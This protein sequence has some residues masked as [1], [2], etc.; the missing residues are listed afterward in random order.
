MI[1]KVPPIPFSPLPFPFLP[2]LPSFF[3]YVKPRQ[4]I[5]NWCQ[6]RARRK[7]SIIGGARLS[8]PTRSLLLTGLYTLEWREHVKSG[9]LHTCDGDES[10]GLECEFQTGQRESS[11]QLLMVRRG[12]QNSCLLRPTQAIA[13]CELGQTPAAGYIRRAAILSLPLPRKGDSDLIPQRDRM[14]SLHGCVTVWTWKLVKWSKQTS[15]WR[16]C[17]QSDLKSNC[18]R[19]CKVPKFAKLPVIGESHWCVNYTISRERAANCVSQLEHHHS[20]KN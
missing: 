10:Q 17:I 7:A 14:R 16:V 18:T 11:L 20:P 8:W 2:F 15:R 3:L 19:V 13:Q 6:P 12:G 9:L 5:S 1:I 4:L